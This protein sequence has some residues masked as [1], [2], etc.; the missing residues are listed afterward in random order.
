MT[1]AGANSLL[2]AK[3][4]LFGVQKFPVR[5]RRE[6]GR[7]IK[8]LLSNSQAKNA[9]IGDLGNIPCKIPCYRHPSRSVSPIQSDRKQL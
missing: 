8:I 5:P 1:A 4:S 7:N 6:F 9:K 3:S 2:S